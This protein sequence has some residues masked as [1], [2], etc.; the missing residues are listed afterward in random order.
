MRH[1]AGS[2]LMLLVTMAAALGCYTINLKVSSERAAVE[3]LR[4]QLVADARDMRNLQAELRTRARLPDMQRWNDNVLLMSAPVA[5]QFLRSPVQLASYGAAPARPEVQYAVATPD[6]AV[7]GAALT[8]PVEKTAY[9]PD[10][11]PTVIAAATPAAQAPRIIRASYAA[12]PVASVRDPLAGLVIDVEPAAARARPT[13][14][15]AHVVAPAAA[16]P[17]AD[18]AQ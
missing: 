11:A 6:A 14:A 12:A 13:R 15:P 2:A 3:G 5:G 4:R 17:L 16:A 9:R 18:G 1:Y 10:V 8:T 7:A